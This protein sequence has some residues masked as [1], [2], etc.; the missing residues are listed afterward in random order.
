MIIV[1]LK[2]GLGNQMFQYAFAK[3]LAI[4]KNTNFSLDTRYLLDRTPQHNFVHRNYDLDIFIVEDAIFEG[5][6]LLP[7]EIYLDKLKWSILKYLNIKFLKQFHLYYEPYSDF[8]KDFLNI[9]NETYCNGYFQSYKY[10]DSI[11]DTILKNFNFKNE[12]SSNCI[13]ILRD[14]KSTNSVCMN[15]RRSDFVSSSFHDVIDD[16]Y[17]YNAIEFLNSKFPDLHIY[18]FSDDIEWCEKNLNFINP[19]TLVTHQFAGDKFRSY[20]ELMM[21]CNHFIIPNSSFAWWAAYLSKSIGKVVIAP[22]IWDRD[23][24]KNDLIPSEWVRM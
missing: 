15:F 6:K 13:N 1:R 2:G 18:I 20:L 5:R 7:Y 24:M 17:Y 19:Y 9:S 14:I 21:E 11:K 23:G 4:N 3:S 16:K 12:L 8:N 10:F 22:K